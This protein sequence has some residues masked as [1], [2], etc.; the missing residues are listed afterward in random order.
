MAGSQKPTGE[1]LTA[2]IAGVLDVESKVPLVQLGVSGGGLDGE[3]L[4]DL[5]EIVS[6]ELYFL[7]AGGPH[8]PCDGLLEVKYLLWVKAND[9]GGQQVGGHDVIGDGDEVRLDRRPL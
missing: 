4:E 5:V 8:A 9:L 6:Q 2:G 3:L 1:G 7:Q